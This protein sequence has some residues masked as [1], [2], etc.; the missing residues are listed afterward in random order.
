MNLDFNYHQAA[1]V[2]AS[3]VKEKMEFLQSDNRDR[4]LKSRGTEDKNGA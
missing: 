2:V 3:V 4:K 1:N